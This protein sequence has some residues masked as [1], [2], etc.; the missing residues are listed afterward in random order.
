[1]AFISLMLR[2]FTSAKIFLS[3]GT[4][5][6]LAIFGFLIVLLKISFLDYLC[7]LLLVFSMFLSLSFCSR[8]NFSLNTI[9][10]FLWNIPL[11]HSTTHYNNSGCLGPL[12]PPIN[13]FITFSPGYFLKSSSV[14][15]WGTIESKVPEINI[16]GIFD[17]FFKQSMGL[18]L[19]I[20]KPASSLVFRFIILSAVYI[21]KSGI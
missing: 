3:F 2:C 17:N 16:H 12:C 14:Y 9:L 21:R 15:L 5:K 10:F 11:T 6:L 4:N 20:S 8:K 7:C 13:D 1:M 18:I 19:K